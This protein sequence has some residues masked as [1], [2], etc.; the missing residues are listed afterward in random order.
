MVNC[1]LCNHWHTV[2]NRCLLGKE[3]W[4]KDV[5][6]NCEK[7]DENNFRASILA[8]AIFYNKIKRLESE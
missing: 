1:S 3:W 6:K 8:K 7:Y 2:E 4:K 5:S